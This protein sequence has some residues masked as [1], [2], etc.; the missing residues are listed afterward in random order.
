MKKWIYFVLI[1]IFSAVFLVS[2][3][4]LLDYYR[5]D[6]KAEQAYDDLSAMVSDARQEVQ[7]TAPSQ[8]EEETDPEPVLVEVTNPETGEIRRVLP[9]YA[10][11]F[12]M[13]PDV[14][15]W[16]KIPG[17]K[18]DYPVM[19]TPDRTDYYLK[20]N[21][22]KKRSAAGSI[23]VREQCDVFVPS[24][25][26]TIY[27]HRMNSGS[28]F[29]QLM[30]YK[31]VEFWAENRYIYFDTL[32]HRGTY[33]IFAV[34]KI[35][36]SVNNGFQY[37]LF[38]DMDRESFTEFVTQCKE[39][40]LYNT[41]ITPQYGDKLITLSTCEKGSSNTRFVVVAREVK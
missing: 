36:A 8:P 7:A 25:N 2:G 11:L 27:G 10:E 40:D 22:E 16:I 29:G 37:H 21:F 38:V 3:W 33:E 6:Q 41:G 20:R 14:V 31:K 34:F 24:D 13:N 12:T 15:G 35:S 4:L 19:Q 28:M 18:V 23:Y 30:N 32:T 5:K 26:L 17:T 39:R 1:G 9:E